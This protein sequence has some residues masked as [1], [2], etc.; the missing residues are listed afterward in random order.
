MLALP[1]IHI[2]LIYNIFM[3]K[4]L[5][6]FYKPQV[7]VSEMSDRDVLCKFTTRCEMRGERISGFEDMLKQTFTL[8]QKRRKE[9]T[10]K[11]ALRTQRA[12][13]AAAAHV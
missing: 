9:S 11:G 13:A 6:Y 1:R 8:K 12:A 3:F 5:K 2:I 10:E 4:D 7:E